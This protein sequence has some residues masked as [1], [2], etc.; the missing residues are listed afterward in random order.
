MAKA[1]YTTALVH[2]NPAAQAQLKSYL[3]V[4]DQFNYAITMLSP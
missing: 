2:G 4:K 1:G 3:I